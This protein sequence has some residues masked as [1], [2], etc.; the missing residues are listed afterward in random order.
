MR[1]VRC[2]PTRHLYP[3][4]E[5]VSIFLLHDVGATQLRP[6]FADI[7]MRAACAL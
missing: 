6:R 5:G 4:G 1:R 3:A 2:Q 7:Q